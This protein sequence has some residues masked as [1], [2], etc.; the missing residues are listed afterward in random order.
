LNLFCYTGS[1]TVYAAAGGARSTTSVDLSNT[2]LDWAHENLLLNGFGGP[3]H[4][5]YRADCLEWL[6]EQEGRALRLSYR[7]PD[8]A[9]GGARIEKT[10]RLLEGN[11]F[12]VDYDVVLETEAATSPRGAVNPFAAPL[13]AGVEQ[14]FVAVNSVATHFGGAQ[15]TLFCWPVTGVAPLAV[16]PTEGSAGTPAH[17]ET[18]ALG[19]AQFSLPPSASRLEVRTPGK[20]T[21]V[22]EWKN[23]VMTVDMKIYSALLRLEFPKLRPGGA[24][25]RPHVEFTLVPTE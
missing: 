18:F 25:V 11:R 16:A 10:I 17:C 24:S 20:P 12:A 14:A 5:L 21:L 2:Y 19:R 3:S 13:P 6:E 7:A 23:A 15:S 8:V 4:E 9:P 1:A 22:M